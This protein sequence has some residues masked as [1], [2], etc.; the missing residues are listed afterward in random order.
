MLLVI[1][2]NLL[3][4]VMEHS[5]SI[6]IGPRFFVSFKMLYYSVIPKLFVAWATRFLAWPYSSSICCFTFS[7]VPARLV[8]CGIENMQQS[9]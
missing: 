2:I 4:V 7:P 8:C 6:V 3:L 5:F 1:F 9:K